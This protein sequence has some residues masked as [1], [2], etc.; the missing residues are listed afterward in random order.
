MS[1]SVPSIS[2]VFGSGGRLDL[3]CPGRGATSEREPVE[4]TPSVRGGGAGS[5]TSDRDRMRSRVFIATLGVRQSRPLGNPGGLDSGNSRQLHDLPL[6][7]FC[8]RSCWHA[9]FRA[10]SFAV[11]SAIAIVVA[12]LIDEV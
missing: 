7:Q 10:L 2:G 9:A 11:P 3:V 6:G 1:S 4:V 5:G 12:R 8:S